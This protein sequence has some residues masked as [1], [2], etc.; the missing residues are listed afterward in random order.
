MSKAT[1]IIQYVAPVEVRID[2]PND[3]DA[4]ENELAVLFRKTAP[5]KRVVSSELKPL[6]ADFDTSF[7]AKLI[8]QNQKS[9][10]KIEPTTPAG[11]KKL[12][13]KFSR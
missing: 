4:R 7:H 9:G 12:L 13:E 6:P 11:Y 2:K 3:K 5:K 10:K 8:R 1:R